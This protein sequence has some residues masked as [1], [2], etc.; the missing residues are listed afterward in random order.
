MGTTIKYSNEKIKY[1]IEKIKFHIQKIGIENVN[2]K[3]RIEMIEILELDGIYDV[4]IEVSE[5]ETEEKKTQPSLME[6]LVV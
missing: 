3:L 1:S 2:E 5:P 4:E 6:G